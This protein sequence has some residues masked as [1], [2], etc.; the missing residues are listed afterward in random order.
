MT[1]VRFAV[2]VHIL[3]LLSHAEEPCTSAFVAGS[4]NTHPVVVRRMLGMLQRAGL[5]SAQA[6]PRG[7]FRIAKEPKRITLANV[8]AAVEDHAAPASHQPNPRCPVGRQV[9]GIVTDIGRRAEK[10]FV[11][12]LADQ[13]IADVV[14]DVKRKAGAA[15]RC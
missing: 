7:G 11:A 3:T 1:N 4:V 5:V 10:A 15:A 2:A 6:G 13:T 8:F 12:S 9:K 14:R